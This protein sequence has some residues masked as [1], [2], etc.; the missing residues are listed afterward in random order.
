ME[1]P[2]GKIKPPAAKLCR[3]IC[4]R[5]PS[6]RK[7]DP[8]AEKAAAQSE[9]GQEA[10]L[11]RIGRIGRIDPVAA[12]CHLTYTQLLMTRKKDQVAE[13]VKAQAETEE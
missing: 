7:G 9:T 5:L 13:T 10:L 8:A 2:R 6:R 12:L 4:F 11:G 3:R 1:D